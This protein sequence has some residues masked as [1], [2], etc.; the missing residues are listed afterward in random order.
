MRSLIHKL[1]YN[2]KT[3]RAMIRPILRLHN[4]CYKLAGRWS[5]ILNNGIHPKHEI[6][7]YQQWFAE[8]IESAWTVIDVG[9]HT[10]QMTRKIAEK[11]KFVYGVEIDPG[12]VEKTREGKNPD[13]IE[14]ICADI[15]QLDY[16]RLKKIDCVLLSNVLEHIENRQD[17]LKRMI[18]RIPWKNAGCKKILIRV[19]LI[20]REWI[21]LYKKQMGVEYRLDPTHFIEYTQQSFWDEMR[22]AGI[23]IESMEIRFGEIYAVCFAKP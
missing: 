22:T 18:E 2:R 9:C 14:Y 17:F 1:I 16:D 20:D 15:T 21:V 5:V 13:N 12:N 6:L 10:G 11:A 19:P 8:N 4:L 7:R 23:E 3:A